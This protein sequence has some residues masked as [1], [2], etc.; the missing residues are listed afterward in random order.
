MMYNLIS[1]LIEAD[2]FLMSSSDFSLFLSSALT[3]V[4]GLEFVKLLCRHKPD[5]LIDVLMLAI[6]RQMVVEHLNTYEMLL[7]V[8][9]VVCLLVAKKFFKKSHKVFFKK[10]NKKE[11]YN[12]DQ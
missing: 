9:S 4:V 11:N 1:D 7:G 8:L 3:L 10:L 6:S 2:I 5:N 12:V